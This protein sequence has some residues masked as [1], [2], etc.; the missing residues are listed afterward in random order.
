[1]PPL[2]DG[3]ELTSTLSIDKPICWIKV[4]LSL[5]VPNDFLI[6]NIL[7][8]NCIPLVNRRLKEKHVVKSNYDRI[9]LPMPT[10]DLFLDVHKVQDAKNRGD[11]TEYKRVDFLDTDNLPGMYTLRSGSRVR[12][13]NREDAS[14]QIYRLLEVVRDEYS[15]FKEEGVNRLKEDF[16]VIEKA[17]NRIKSQLPD[18]YRENEIKSSYFC[19][20][21]FRQGASRLNYQYWETQGEVI[22]HLGDK[23]GLVVTSSDITIANSRSV[24][25]IQRGK[26]EL[27]SDD[28]INQLRISLL[29][30]GKILTKADI[31]LYCKS[32]Y[33]CSSCI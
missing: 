28:Y 20:A 2:L 9:L 3:S 23:T 31:K 30:R 29:S 8:P 17:I 25:P 10:A 11:G 12:R 16:D 24:I 15:T 1:M 5:A 32:R 6:K 22:K 21:N 19:I 27:T 13:L 14:R 7:Y 4:E 18:L 26:G 33:G